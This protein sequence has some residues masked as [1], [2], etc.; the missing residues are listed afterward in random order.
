[1]KARPL[2]VVDLA[3]ATRQIESMAPERWAALYGLN[4]LAADLERR[5]GDDQGRK[6]VL[7]AAMAILN[8]PERCFRYRM[9][10]N[11][12]PEGEP[13]YRCEQAIEDILA[14]RSLDYWVFRY[15]RPSCEA[16][17]AP[18]GMELPPED[19]A[20]E[21]PWPPNERTAWFQRVVA[22]ICNPS[23]LA[24]CRQELLS[25]A[26]YD[27]FDP[28]EVDRCQ[29]EGDNLRC[30]DMTPEE[31][32]AHH[33]HRLLCGGAHHYR[34][35]DPEVDRF[36]RGVRRICAFGLQD[37]ARRA[38]LTPAQWVEQEAMSWYLPL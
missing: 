17:F 4:F 25:T 22:V 12:P 31:W 7:A 10:L 23:L 16:A 35:P 21:P 18:L 13:P 38:H 1:M 30:S 28:R 8:T 29:V 14:H 33:Y 11:G 6:D 19:E 5:V 32:V 9:T 20:H 36:W 3:E 15:A 27:L 37:E 26:E 2:P 24:Y 34:F